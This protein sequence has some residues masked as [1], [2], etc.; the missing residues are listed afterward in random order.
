[1]FKVDGVSYQVAIPYGGLRRIFEIKEGP[2]SLTY[3]G[4]DYDKDVV[5]TYYHYSVQ[6]IPDPAAP[7]AY[8]AFYEVISAPVKS[9]TVEFMYGQDTLT[10]E[11][12]IESGEDVF[13]QTLG[14]K[15]H[16]KGL[17]IQFRAKKPQREPE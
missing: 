8:D 16:W 14:T 17:E 11:A 6:V 1:M 3:I 9:H 2:G 10:F 4:G 12:F 15:K 7:E 5:G 13:D